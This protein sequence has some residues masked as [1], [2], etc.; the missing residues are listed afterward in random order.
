MFDKVERFIRDYDENRYL[1]VFGLKYDFLR[2]N[3]L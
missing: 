2:L 1:V 3:F